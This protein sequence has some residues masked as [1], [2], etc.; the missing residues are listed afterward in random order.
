MSF[1]SARAAAERYV[2]AVNQRGADLLMELFAPNATLSH[3]AGTY[4]GH[5][6]IRNFYEGLVFRAE[7]TVA[8]TRLVADARV[9][10]AELTGSSP[11]SP[12][13][14]HLVDVFEVDEDGKIVH[15]GI[16]AR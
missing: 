15:L 4:R 16:Y 13:P 7:T 9:A 5:Q 11:F 2:V 6:E 12:S 14:T 1:S 3:P 8:V 10:F